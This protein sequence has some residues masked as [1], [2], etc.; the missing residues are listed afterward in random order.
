MN[1]NY[2]KNV[3]EVL[4]VL[5]DEANGNVKSALSRLTDDYSMTWV[6]QKKDGTFFPTTGKNIDDELAE[7]YPIRNRKYIIK[8][9]AE[10]E[11]V[12]MVELIESYPD[13]DTG[14]VY[15]TPLV[16]VLEIKNN[17]IRTGRHYCDPNLS[18]ANLPE[19]KI[20]S[21]YKNQQTTPFEIN[22]ER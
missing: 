14:V 10:G 1:K 12:V 4:N 19:A 18:Y 8:N 9:I 11:G 15:R 22:D 2:S 5:Q 16:L 13:P 21:L 6:Y 7:V 17:K 20:E 3:Q